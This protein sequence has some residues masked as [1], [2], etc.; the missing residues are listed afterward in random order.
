MSLVNKMLRDL[1]ARRAAPGERAALP[2]AVTP[3]AARQESPRGREI[4][5]GALVA[6]VALGVA[7][8]WFAPAAP[9]T[10]V[11]VASP[12]ATASTVPSPAAVP[13][14]PSA[15]DTVSGPAGDIT[16]APAG[17]RSV[18]PKPARVE[19]QLRIDP[20]LAALPRERP[21]SRGKPLPSVPPAPQAVAA[22]AAVASAAP[23]RPVAAIAVKEE[24]AAESSI[25]K[26]P[27]LPTAV[28]RAEADY[29]RGL[30]AQRQG[31]KDEAAARYQAA[32][33][34]HAGHA[35]AR[36]SLAALL[37]ELR[38]YDEAD[39]LLRKGVALPAVRLASALALA[40]LMVERGQAA[41]AL[42]LLLENA[43]AGE[44]SADYQGFVAALL[45]RAGRHR[46]AAERYQAAVQLAPNE[47][48]W[49][50]GLGI[51]LEAEGKPAEAR[52]AYQ[53]A[54]GLPGLPA[55]LALH[56]EQRLR[57]P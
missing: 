38:R 33:A 22:D 31:Q 46:E 27:R 5:L 23:V 14:A 16:L 13:S 36:Q 4:W 18:R 10:A 32:L 53:K 7:W 35:A 17:T 40:R 12:M 15:R 37:I 57:Q 20:D 2:A 45:N 30:L 29:R 28:E 6:S 42:D 43:A 3:L 47:S 19:T 50:A 24:P 8:W 44:R 49:W 11:V 9:R 21:A 26:Q 51:A 1:D 55:E 48:R 52:A 56:I 34:E 39:A 54:S 41:A 25:N